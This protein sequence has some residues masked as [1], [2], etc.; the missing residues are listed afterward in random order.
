MKAEEMSYHEKLVFYATAKRASVGTLSQ[1]VDGDFKKFFV[2][3]LNGKIVSRYPDNEYRF[4]TPRE[5]LE[6]AR[7]FRNHA[8]KEL[9]AMSGAMD[10]PDASLS[11]L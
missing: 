11:A 3:K 6:A 9:N 10:A 4:D 8:Q 7:S 5:A 2:G 1:I